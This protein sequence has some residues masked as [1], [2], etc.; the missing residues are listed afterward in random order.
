MAITNYVVNPS[1]E[2][3]LTSWTA[4]GCTATR[5]ATATPGTGG[6]SCKMVATGGSAMQEAITVAG[7]TIGKYYVASFYSKNTFTTFG[8]QLTIAG[9]TSE[10]QRS[11]INAF[12]R[13]RVG[14]TATA[15][16]H[17]LVIASD[18]S[19]TASDTAYID[20]VSITDGN[21]IQPYFDGS[22]PFST[23]TG[24]A[25]AST[26]TN[27][28]F[29]I[30]AETTSEAVVVN[31]ICLNT[32]AWN[33]TTKT[34]RY[35]L[36][37]TRGDN[38]KVPSGRGSTFIPNKP[39]DDGIWTLSMFLLGAN[40]DGTVPRRAA[41]R[42]LFE[43]NLAAILN[44]VL[45]Y[46]APVTIYA[47]QADGSVRKTN[48]TLTGSNAVDVTMTMG[49]ARGEFNLVFDVLDGV[50]TDY[51]PATVAGTASAAW[52]NQ[53][54]SLAPVL[55]GGTV[56]I[57]DAVITVQGP[58]TNPRVTNAATGTWVQYTG[59]LSSIQSW[60]I[61]SSQFTSKVNTVSVLANT[62]HFGAPKFLVIDPVSPQATLT[63]TG[64]GVQTNLSITAA[65]Q[66]T[67]A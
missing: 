30:G 63:C 34:G 6:F 4:T 56:P 38:A 48:A 54:L 9:N 29:A 26:S 44:A 2:T 28:V 41:Q 64:S 10:A 25:N 49:G 27:S 15:T 33:I 16:S 58:A 37:N 11:G 43:Q 1:F 32:L 40:P 45:S 7:L 36:P 51:I 46:S 67:Y 62:T 47:W 13:V 59:T 42:I 3:N 65:R 35:S 50:W 12:V 55:S 17:S 14:F 21:L 23:W 22:Y 20:M 5:D 66:H 52:S 61:D 39:I 57:E 18:T 24:T 8:M 31:G 60:V 19:N 53:T